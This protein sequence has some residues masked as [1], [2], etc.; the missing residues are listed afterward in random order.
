MAMCATVRLCSCLD[1]TDVQLYNRVS[2]EDSIT[3]FKEVSNKAIL[4]ENCLCSRKDETQ[5]HCQQRFVDCPLTRKCNLRVGA[6]GFELPDAL[7]KVVA[8]P[9]LVALNVNLQNGFSML[10]RRVTQLGIH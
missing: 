5:S 4:F 9:Y 10:I 2:C 3:R 7:T 8:A 6:C 1:S